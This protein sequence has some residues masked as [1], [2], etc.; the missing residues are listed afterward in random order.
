MRIV[1]KIAIIVLIGGAAA[2]A[3]Y[4]G[5]NALRRENSGS[6]VSWRAFYW[7]AEL[8]LK[9]ATGEVPDLSWVELW[10]MLRRPGG[11]SLEAIFTLGSSLDGA[12]TNPFNSTKDIDAG[13]MIFREHCVLCHGDAGAALHAPPLDRA[14]FKYGDSDLSIY[15]VL[16]DGI[17]NSAMAASDLSFVQRWQLIGYLRNL[18]IQ[19]ADRKPSIIKPNVPKVTSQQ[20]EAYEG[21]SGEWLTYSGSF[22]GWR[23]SPLAEITPANVANLRIRWIRQF[24]SDDIKYES[25]PLVVGDLMFLTVPPATVVA[26]NAKTGD[27]VWTYARRLPD[28]LPICCGRVNRGLAILGDTLFFGSLDGYLVA[29]NAQSGKV[30]WQTQVARSS[31]GY[32]MTGAPLALKD[33]VVVGVAGGEFGIRGMLAAYDAATGERRWKFDT[34]PGPGD[35]GHDTWQGDAWKTG[36]GSTWVTGS[37]DPSLDLIYWGVANPSPPFSGDV[38]PGDNLFTNSVVAL[39]ASTG[40][41]V[42]HFQFTPHDER[43]WDSAQTPIL[44][45]IL[46]KGVDRKVICWPNRNGFYYVLDRSTGEF[47]VGV[48]YVE[49]NWADGLTAAGRPVPS[50][51]SNTIGHLIRPSVIGGMNWQPAAFDPRRSLIFVPAMEGASVFTKSEPDKIVRGSTG[52]LLGSWGAV[53]KLPAH[54]MRAL[55][56]ATGAKRWVYNPPRGQNGDHSGVLATAG[57]LVFGSSGGDVFA[58][59]ADTGKELWFLPVGGNTLAPPISFTL[60]GRQVIAVLAGQSLLVLGL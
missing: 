58:L 9:K 40:R 54:S 42:W 33:S 32:S 4:F 13:R 25:T 51:E 30:V 8:A 15:K 43:D 55:D 37:Y 20:I 50:K 60:D 11:F 29:L 14:G 59:D 36:G 48:P 52:Q 19:A 23:Y 6:E 24:R 53:V 18:Q 57:G 5:N 45:D 12:V 35:F 2:A 31:E 17:P 26:L 21:R 22:A 7:R 3:F 56:A 28:N 34:I 49:Q 27:V 1:R 38:R 44:A 10:E 46:V 47:L 16:R 39:N 41:L